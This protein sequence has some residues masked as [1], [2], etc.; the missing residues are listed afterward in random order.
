VA[1]S[2][3]SN[4]A[5]DTKDMFF[6]VVPKKVN[7]PF[8]F[9]ADVAQLVAAVVLGTIKFRFESERRHDARKRKPTRVDFAHALLAARGRLFVQRCDDSFRLAVIFAC[10]SDSSSS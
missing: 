1:D 4:L 10:V 2:A 8:T 6:G 5:R 7:V 3:S 9:F